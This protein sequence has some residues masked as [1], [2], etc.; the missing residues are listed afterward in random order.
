MGAVQCER[1]GSAVHPH[2][3]D[4]PFCERCGVFVEAPS[5]FVTSRADAPPGSYRDQAGE[6]TFRLEHR[7]RGDLKP[8]LRKAAGVCVGVV[9]LLGLLVLLTGAQGMCF[10]IWVLLGAPLLAAAVLAFGASFFGCDSR[11]S[12][13]IADGELRAGRRGVRLE[14]VEALE[15]KRAAGGRHTLF[16]RT[17]SGEVALVPHLQ[18]ERTAEEVRVALA[19]EVERRRRAG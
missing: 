1:C 14:E 7:G 8:K 10:L 13:H 12:V 3:G 6:P 19:D 2:G 17:P 4:R 16:A 11:T 15:V 5:W 9:G 18:D